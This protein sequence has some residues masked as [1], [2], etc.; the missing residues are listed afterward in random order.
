MAVTI[1]YL[2]EVGNTTNATSYTTP[3]VSW[4]AG[5]LLIVGVFNDKAT[6]PDTPTL[7]G[8]SLTWTEIA[9]LV[10]DDGVERLTAFRASPSSLG[11]GTLTADF[12]GNTQTGCCILVLL[13][14]GADTSN[15]IV[16]LVIDSAPESLQVLFN[17]PLAAFADPVN[18]ASFGLVAANTRNGLAPFSGETE[19]REVRHATPNAALQA[20]WVAGQDTDQKW[21]A[22]GGGTAPSWTG[23]AMEI[24]VASSVILAG[25]DTIVEI[26]F[27]ANPLDALS[28]VVWTDVTEWVQSG[29]TRRGRNHELARMDA[30][31]ATVVLR[32]EDARFDPLNGSSPYSPNVRPLRRIRISAVHNSITYRRFVGYI[33]AWRQGYEGP[34][35][36][37]V[38]VECVDAFKVLNLWAKTLVPYAQELLDLGP[39]LYWRLGESVGPTALDETANARHGTYRANT[40]LGQ[41]SL[42]RHDPD[43]SVTCN[44]GAQPAIGGGNILSFERTDPWT[45]TF[46]CR[47][48]TDVAA[49]PFI[50]GRLETGGNRG[51]SVGMDTVGRLW[52]LIANDFGGGNLLSVVSA[53]NVD[54][55]V[56]HHIVV[57]YS[58]T[59][60]A[61]GIKIYVDGNPSATVTI[62]DALSATIIAAADFEV[63]DR[64]VP[65][66]LDEFAI[67]GSAITAAQALTLYDE[68][69]EP[70][71]NRRSSQR[72]TDVLDAIGWPAADR[73]IRTGIATLGRTGPIDNPLDHCQQVA[74]TELGAFY[75]AA[76]GKIRFDERYVNISV[77]PTSAATLGDG[78]G[79]IP[80]QELVP[81]L[82]DTDLWTEVYATR[83]D[84][85]AQKS[86]DASAI[87]SYGRRTLTRDGLWIDDNQAAGVAEKLKD[88]YSTPVTR[89]LRV[90]L[91]PRTDACA[92]EMLSRELH[93][94]RVTV[95]RRPPGGGTNTIVCWVE[96]I[97]HTFDASSMRAVFALV[98]A[99]AATDYWEL[100]SNTLGTDTILAY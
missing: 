67:V 77:F 45:V 40:T 3:S 27:A 32:N 44:P 58:G 36:A 15:P 31:T 71:A 7:S 66:Q 50:C 28:I 11:S 68:Y 23:F 80:Y 92:V 69:L 8:G 13:A 54:D 99:D 76:D 22:G 2:A 29:E 64:H 61:S 53:Q 19:L 21:Q 63:G 79:E 35:G 94:D 95:T 82:D 49:S 83:P 12:A 59:S 25:I 56:T 84:G 9:T 88:R 18:N 34:Y 89:F 73:D 91:V 48:S 72:V 24:G 43:R 96:G 81:E 38:T 62:T 85:V 75:V 98:P 37:T 78:A 17:I 5:D 74:D 97:A 47:A 46:I 51:W 87:D 55:G 93:R 70:W 1:S 39:E 4:S 14:T 41:E 65:I 90:G 26:G 52:V 100:G 10:S 16:Q 86:S 20:Q 6:T 33:E 42:L 57:T 60:A 30:G